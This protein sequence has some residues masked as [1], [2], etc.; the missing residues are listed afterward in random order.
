MR[1]DLWPEE[2]VQRLR[3]LWGSGLSTAE[4]G[5]RLGMSKCAVVGKA[6]RT[7]GCARKPLPII[8][9]NGPKPVPTTP[10]ERPLVTL[11]PLSEFVS[12]VAAAIPVTRQPI[13]A[14]PS[15]IVTPEPAS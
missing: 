1:D 4:I 6:H 8:R 9:R 13:F 10:R 7:E 11:P 2:K 15:R 14:P 3:E 5:R 12:P